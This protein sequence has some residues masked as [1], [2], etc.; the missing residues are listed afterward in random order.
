MFDF[1]KGKS[2]DKVLSEQEIQ[3]KLYGRF[4]TNKNSIAGA[5]E[6]YTRPAVKSASPSSSS[7]ALLFPEETADDS[8]VENRPSE[9][10][11]EARPAEK[12]EDLREPAAAASPKEVYRERLQNAEQDFLKAA[13]GRVSAPKVSFQR[14]LPKV[15]LP[16]LPLRQ[17][18]DSMLNGIAVFF[19]AIFGLLFSIGRVVDFR[20]EGVRSGLAWGSGVVALVLLLAA[21]QGLN[22][23]REIAMKTAV[24][25][26]PKKVSAKAEV[27]KSIPVS[28]ESGTARVVA[29]LVADRNDSPLTPAAEKAVP[30]NKP[31]TAAT[32]SKGRF[33]IQVATYVIRDD[34]ER[35]L[36]DIQKIEAKA[37]VKGLSRSS[38][39][40]YYSVFLGRFESFKDGQQALAA[41]KKTDLSKSFKDAFIRTLE[42]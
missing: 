13:R 9:L 17:V 36:K 29:P 42:A 5:S 20:R 1:K 2:S 33:V 32:A 37:F 26:A 19:N 23:K 8:A 11:S 27:R 25:K 14:V 40:T 3:Q 7:A 41:F 6:S 10:I 35:L 16:K 30:I 22:S 24:P 28:L 15:Q 39:K 18:F 38:G 4:L 31:E 34:A 21:I 12:R